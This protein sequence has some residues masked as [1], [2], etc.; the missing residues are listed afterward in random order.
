[1][2]LL[3]FSAL[4]NTNVT[5]FRTGIGL[6][7]YVTNPIIPLTNGGTGASN[8]AQARTN[9]GLGWS[10]LTNT[11]FGTATNT[12]CQGNDA[13]IAN[14]GSGTI[15]TVDF[16]ATT[17]AR[18]EIRT[19]PGGNLGGYIDLRGG[20]GANGGIIDTHG[21]FEDSSDH[22]GDISTYGAG[23][24]A[25][26]DI[27]TYGGAA[28]PGGSIDTSDDG[29]SINTRG[30]GSIGFGEN[31][32]R[33]TLVGSPSGSDKTVTLPSQAG[34]LALLTFSALTNT[35]VANFRTDIGLGLSALTNTNVANFRTD[36]GLGLS[37]LTNTN[38]ANFRTDIGLGLSALTN[39][40]VTNFRT[41]I[42]LGSGISGTKRITNQ[43][44][45]ALVTNVITISNGII[46]GWTP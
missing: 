20:D 42:G 17:I 14:I 46:T 28:G 12:F 36:I 43:V 3:T 13:R 15:N 4:T 30:Y 23:G 6:A 1:L 31:G 19:G 26:G 18:G 27:S 44:G 34:T 32:N 2:A 22:G 38:V 37:A 7:S 24:T 5:N 40:N 41:D 8:I 16:G 45:T 9:L 11:S 33:T 39:T 10:A 25:G 29:G 21:G 35:N